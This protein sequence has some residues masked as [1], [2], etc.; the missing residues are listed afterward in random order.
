MEGWIKL[1]RKLLDW[2][3]FDKS[4]MVHLFVYFLLRANHKPKKWRNTEV[5]TGQFITTLDEISKDTGVSTRTIRT[6]LDRFESTGVLTS[7][8]T[9]RN[10]LITICNYANYQQSE[11]EID[12]Q[13][14]SPTDRQT[15]SQRQATD[16]PV[17]SYNNKKE[18]N[19]IN[20]ILLT[21]ERDKF[22]ERKDILLT[23]VF[24]IESNLRVNKIGM[25]EFKNW[26]EKFFDMLR[27]SGKTDIE[28]EEAMTY[29]SNWL[30]EQLS[31]QNKQQKQNG[32]Y[33]QTTGSGKGEQPSTVKV[34]TVSVG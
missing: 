26:L 25:D 29:F 8:S 3:W 14:D 6:C 22:D 11:N 16:K 27:C 13:N 4:E 12:K 31:K 30:R 33:K 34:R 1:H 17:T 9:N 5:Q 7:E 2:E 24:W 20:N 32:A 28:E 19:I 23:R 18:E 10:R 15:T 21:R